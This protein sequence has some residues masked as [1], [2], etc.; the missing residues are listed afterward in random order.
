MAHQ[1]IQ[2]VHA[3]GALW[4]GS[5]RTLF[6]EYGRV[7]APLAACSLQHQNFDVELE[8]LPGRYAPPRGCI[9]LA[10]D[11]SSPVGCIALRPLDHLGRGVGELKRMYVRPAARRRGVGRLLAE[12][13]IEF[14]IGQRYTAIKLDTSSTM[15]EAMALYASLGFVP[16]DRYND[17]PMSDT[18]WFERTLP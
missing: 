8:S 11:E 12:R 15:H 17:D 3:E 14:A 16:C 10:L 9:L 18:L 13:L 5:A 4:L 6:A 2:I 7:I 1:A